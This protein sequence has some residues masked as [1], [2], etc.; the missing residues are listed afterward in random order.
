MRIFFVRP[1]KHDTDL[2][3]IYALIFLAAFTFLG[4][5]YPRITAPSHM[6]ASE[7]DRFGQVSIAFFPSFAGSGCVFRD[8]TGIPCFACGGTRAAY[9]TLHLNFGRAMTYNPL[10]CLGTAGIAVWTLCI[11]AA[12]AFRTDRPR[13][14]LSRREWLVAKLLAVLAVTANWVFLVS[15]RELIV[16]PFEWMSQ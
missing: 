12:R 1:E 7:P 10:V 4:A 14:A 8:A 2:E 11:L 5:L 13:I 3:F 16:Q 15:N 9:F 6:C